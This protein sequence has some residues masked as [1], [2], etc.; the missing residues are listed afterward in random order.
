MLL[1]S[2]GGIEEHSVRNFVSQEQACATCLIL[3]TRRGGGIH[4]NIKEL[5]TR[6][7]FLYGG[8]PEYNYNAQAANIGPTLGKLFTNV[9]S[10]ST[11]LFLS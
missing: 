7:F 11:C 4:Q 3:A 5:A 9:D 10:V 8:E 1:L 2:L 6:A